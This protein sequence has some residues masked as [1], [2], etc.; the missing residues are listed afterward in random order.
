M[1]VVHLTIPISSIVI[2]NRWDYDFVI[3]LLYKWIVLCGHIGII[4]NCN[5]QFSEESI[6][7]YVTHITTYLPVLRHT[8]IENVYLCIPKVKKVIGKF[9]KIIII[10]I[11][12]DIFKGRLFNREIFI[13]MVEIFNKIFGWVIDHNI[14]HYISI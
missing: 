13:L 9:L 3:V 4:N 14:T 12:T 10:R 11:L 8:Y 6:A 7:F 2:A 5:C 1:L